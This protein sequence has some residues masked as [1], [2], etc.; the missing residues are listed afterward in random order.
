MQTADEALTNINE[1][2][3]L[4]R[5]TSHNIQAHMLNHRAA[6]FCYTG[7]YDEALA[8]L[9]MAV[10]LFQKMD[11]ALGLMQS[12]LL[13]GF[14]YSQGRQ[15]WKEGRRRLVQVGQLVASQ[16][17]EVWHVCA[18]SCTFVAGVGNYC[19][20]YRAFIAGGNDVSEGAAGN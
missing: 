8:D 14:E 1:A 11:D 10:D 15:D 13:W 12:Y 4:I 5:A 6:I 20:Q 2:I 19:A 7:Q 17:E 18:G 3:T 16:P 9:Q